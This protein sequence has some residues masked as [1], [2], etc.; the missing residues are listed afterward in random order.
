M[1]NVLARSHAIGIA[2]KSVDKRRLLVTNNFM[3]VVDEGR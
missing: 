1:Y 3:C 2:M